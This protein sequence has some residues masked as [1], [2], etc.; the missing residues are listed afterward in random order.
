MVVVYG[1][2]SPAVPDFRT[3]LTWW[4]QRL[5]DGR[6][7]HVPD[8]DTWGGGVDEMLSQDPVALERRSDLVRSP[9]DKDQALA[10]A[11]HACFPTR[12]KRSTQD[13]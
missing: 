11:A 13:A 12:E 7:R 8:S 10:D 6:W 4:T 1:D 3:A 2:A 9:P 5:I